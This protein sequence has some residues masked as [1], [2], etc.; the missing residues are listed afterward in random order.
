MSIVYQHDKRSGIT[1]AYESEAHWDKAKKQSRAKRTLIG[2]VDPVTREIVP[3]RPRKVKAEEVEL[4]K[5]L[6]YGATYMLDKIGEQT[7]VVNDLREC[8]P[9]SYR[10][11]LSMAYYMVLEQ[12]SPLSRFPRFS[13]MHRHPYGR[14]I[15]SQRSSEIFK[16]IEESQ[17]LKFF[18]LQ[19]K[20]RLSR[21]Y[22]VYDT[23]S[24]SSY[25]ECLKQVKY[26]YNR[27]HDKLPQI[28][29]ALLFGE[30]SRLPFY[31][32]K[33]S[34]N[35][36]DVKTLK[37]LLSDMPE[38][39]IDKKVKLVMDKGFYSEENINALYKEHIKFLISVRPTLKAVR[40]GV[41][42]LKT[43]INSWSNYN[44]QRKLHMSSQLI[45]WDY[46]QLRR[47]K[48][49][50][51]KE[52]RRM[53]LHLYYNSEHASAEMQEFH[54]RLLSYKS[55]IESGKPLKEHEKQYAKY[56]EVSETPVRG[57]KAIAKQEAIAETESNYGY[58]TLIS[59]EISDA[60]EALDIYRNKDL[61]E[62]AFEDIKDRLNMRRLRVSN[63]VGLDGKLFVEFVA[64]IF[65]SYIK[66]RMDEKGLFEDYT[67]QE[68]LD[69][70][71]T[72]ESYEYLN[73][74]LQVGEI[75]NKQK[76]L[77]ENLNIP[78]PASL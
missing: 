65:L 74:R 49:D 39:G 36:P 42:E 69:E 30:N 23:T 43:T 73:K 71:D 21:E 13:A 37:R 10:E 9:N 2:R 27:E 76:K 16:G 22:L 3:T 61:V 48:G 4:S 53:Y 32:R 18:K 58:F 6:F 64:L 24:I 5:R 38:I 15:S 44:P 62:K 19:G 33:L 17:R 63:N 34:G 77:F 31:Y 25:S 60:A 67:M 41:E 14:V 55:E 11:I 68:V 52:G 1:Y 20:R 50:I 8:F 35:I 59:N 47:Y 26:G 75:T 45:T 29:L 40:E 46:S 54:E 66:K 51:K 78:I 57:V 12:K 28:N 56:F 7:G 70:L 72:I